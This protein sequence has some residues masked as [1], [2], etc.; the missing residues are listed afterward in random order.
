LLV[1]TKGHAFAGVWLRAEEFSSTVVD[2]VTALRKR[3]KL[4]ELLLFET[5]L[6]TQRPAPTFSFA[7]HHAAQQIAEDKEEAFELA[8]DIRRARMQRIKPLASAEAPAVAA[9]PE[10]AA[11]VEPAFDAPPPS[12]APRRS[13]CGA[14]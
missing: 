2:D 4:K 14:G 7:A 8:V 9:P 12:P 3:V 1:F 13:N 5:T 10:P 11:V 6:A